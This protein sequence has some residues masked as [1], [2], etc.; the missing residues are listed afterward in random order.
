[1]EKTDNNLE[2]QSLNQVVELNEISTDPEQEELQRNHFQLTTPRL[3]ND[4]AP[5]QFNNDID[6][7]PPVSESLNEEQGNQDECTRISPPQQIEHFREELG[8]EGEY[9]CPPPPPPSIDNTCI[10]QGSATSSSPVEVIT[11]KQDLNLNTT[12]TDDCLQELP[13]SLDV[14][15][16]HTGGTGDADGEIRN[17][18][19]PYETPANEQHIE[20]LAR[21]LADNLHKDN[22]SPSM[23]SFEEFEWEQHEMRAQHY[24]HQQEAQHRHLAYREGYMHNHDHNHEQEYYQRQHEHAQ[25]THYEH[26]HRTDLTIQITDSAFAPYSTLSSPGSQHY[27]RASQRWYEAEQ[28]PIYENA[29]GTPC[30][31]NDRLYEV[32]IYV[33]IYN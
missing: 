4:S 30:S 12:T 18:S 13:A 7:H 22:L 27:P 32:N 20:L 9:S 28:T 5:N 23:Y 24:M 6:S 21:E 10:E 3:I 25:H 11:G 19:L 29:S 1:M 14:S 15:V 17:S 33:Y 8:K 2:T 16:I 26:G 31:R